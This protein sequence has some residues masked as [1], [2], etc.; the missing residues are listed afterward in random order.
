LRVGRGHIVKK[1]RGGGSRVKGRGAIS[2]V[3]T[4]FFKIFYFSIFGPRTTANRWVSGCPST[5]MGELSELSGTV[6]GLGGLEGPDR[7]GGS[8]GFSKSRI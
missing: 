1:F 2:K 6:W 5:F 4:F 8:F 3:L 7:L